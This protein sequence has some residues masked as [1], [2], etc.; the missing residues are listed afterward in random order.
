MKDQ[1]TP[2]CKN[3]GRDLPEDAKYCAFCGTER[4]KGHFRPELNRS[5]C[6]YAPP[7]TTFFKCKKCG[8]VWKDST[9]G[10]SKM[11]YCPICGTKEVEITKED[12]NWD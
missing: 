1:D 6:V 10:R 3:C 5:A 8:H 7:C 2:Y 4:G 9:L 11:K 12:W